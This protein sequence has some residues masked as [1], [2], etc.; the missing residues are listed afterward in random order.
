MLEASSTTPARCCGSSPICCMWCLA[1]VRRYR[2]PAGHEPTAR[3]LCAN[4]QTLGE[5]TGTVYHRG[6][7]LL[8]QVCVSCS[9]VQRANP[10]AKKGVQWGKGDGAALVLLSLSHR[11]GESG[12]GAAGSDWCSME[13]ESKADEQLYCMWEA[14]RC[15]RSDSKLGSAIGHTP[16]RQAPCGQGPHAGLVQRGVGGSVGSTKIPRA[17]DCLAT[18]RARERGAAWAREGLQ[19]GSPVCRKRSGAAGR[20]PNTHTRTPACSKGRGDEKLSVA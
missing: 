9:A 3:P 5:G 19:R 16:M 8:M 13:L 12:E 6:D 2:C 1:C 11:T 7:K 17:A 18:G 4:G 15:L 14:G 10:R 20:A